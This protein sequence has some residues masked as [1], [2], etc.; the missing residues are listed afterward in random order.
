MDILDRCPRPVLVQGYRGTDQVGFASAVAELLDGSPPE[1]ALRQFG[2]QVRPVQRRRAFAPG[3]GPARLPRLARRPGLA[4]T[5]PAGSGT[6][7]ARPTPPTRTPGGPDGTRRAR[8][9]RRPMIGRSAGTSPAGPARLSCPS[10]TAPS[11]STGRTPRRWRVN[12]PDRVDHA[13]A[14]LQGPRLPAPRHRRADRL[15]RRLPGTPPRCSSIFLCNHCPYVKHVRHGL[16]DAGAR[17]P[18]EGRGR[19][20]HQLQRRGDATPTTAPR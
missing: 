5:T 13:P 10:E 4:R 9:D 7:P 18:G 14:R 16:A 19:R 11:R 20:R 2:L 8:A 3:A 17:V 6:G 15:P 12:G 1:V